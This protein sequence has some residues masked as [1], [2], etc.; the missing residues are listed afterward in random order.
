MARLAGVDIN[1]HWSCSFV[2][3]WVILQGSF[4][5]GSVE[6]VAYA[7]LAVLTL[8][9]CVT[10]HELGHAITA[11]RLNV[12]VKNIILLPVGGMAQM[13]TLPKDP[14]QELLIAGA[15]P[16]VN[17]AVAV[18]LLPVALFLVEDTLLQGFFASPGTVLEGVMQGFFREG[19]FIGLIVFLILSN[20]ILFVFNLI[21]A[22][23][24]DGG[25]VL[26]AVLALFVS[27]DRATQLAMGISWAI[28][29]GLALLALKTRSPGLFLVAFFIFIAGRP[30]KI[31]PN[32]SELSSLD[33]QN[34]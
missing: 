15:G 3:L 34:T 8:F 7:L 12:Q 1:I 33:T 20:I 30:I 32:R 4:G 18:G 16:L 11:L 28:I 24:M 26:R 17:L 2:V 19:A 10:L 5:R 31:K 13:Q 25:R 6:T 27:H 23:P 21:P 29:I 22:F 9:V 14:I